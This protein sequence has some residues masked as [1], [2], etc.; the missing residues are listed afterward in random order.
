MKRGLAR[1]GLAAGLV[2][3]TG[4]SLLFAV[5]DDAA[6]GAA[7]GTLP[8]ALAPDLSTNDAEGGIECPSTRRG[9]E[10]VPA[11][12]FCID[13]TEVTAGQY[14]V[15]L[16]D[17]AGH[18]A[19]KARAAECADNLA[20]AV[21]AT[22]PSLDYPVL[23]D[24]C[25]AF[26]FC[27]WAGKR[28]CG[29]IGEG[30]IDAAATMSVVNGT[31]NSWVA[32]CEGPQR[33]PLPYGDQVIADACAPDPAMPMTQGDYYRNIGPT[34]VHPLCEGAYPGLLDM[35]GN[36]DEWIDACARGTCSHVGATS[37][38]SLNGGKPNWDSGSTF[39]HP[40]GFRCCFP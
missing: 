38:Q 16:T 23:V 26:A 39:Q 20:Y 29:A 27:A 1:V 18:G 37:C 34:G 17:D 2:A 25:D 8:D 12:S 33:R 6:N 11:G 22:A 14:A 7:T 28:L 31:V 35:V 21:R 15:F 10:L 4:C 36:A 3:A 24:W 40:H 32:A 5:S 13:R 19:E 9:P 30:A